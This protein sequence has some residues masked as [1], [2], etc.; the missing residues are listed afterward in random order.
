MKGLLGPS[1]RRINKRRRRKPP[2]RAAAAAVEANPQ[3][4]ILDRCSKSV[5]F[6]AAH[7]ST[8]ERILLDCIVRHSLGKRWTCWP[9]A[10]C[11]ATCTRENLPVPT[12]CLQ[13]SRY[14]PVLRRNVKRLRGGLVFKDHRRLR[15]SGIGS[16]VTKRKK[17]RRRVHPREPPR[18][19][20]LLA[21]GVV[22]SA[23]G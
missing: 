4:V 8:L 13:A 10:R 17:R 23:G 14:G 21:G 3:V 22:L 12:T 20:H 11:V 2:A 1:S 7:P 18:A 19:D 9:V 6:G 5:N 15:H 16:R